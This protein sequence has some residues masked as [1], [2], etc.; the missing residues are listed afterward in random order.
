MSTLLCGYFHKLSSKSGRNLLDLSVAV[1][2]VAEEVAF[3]VLLADEGLDACRSFAFAIDFPKYDA[4]FGGY[5]SVGF[6]MFQGES[7][8]G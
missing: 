4:C 2:D 7:L 1:L 3:F 5:H 8:L 6:C